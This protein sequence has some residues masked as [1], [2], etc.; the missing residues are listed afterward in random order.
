MMVVILETSQELRE[1]E[2]EVKHEEEEGWTAALA[3]VV[4]LVLELSRRFT[5]GRTGDT[6]GVCR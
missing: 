5:Q 2:G 1:K 4:A 6:F 3:L